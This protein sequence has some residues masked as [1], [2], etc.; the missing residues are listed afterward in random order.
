[1]A[2]IAENI[3]VVAEKL[4]DINVSLQTIANA[5]QGGKVTMDLS[6]VEQ[7][8]KDLQFNNITFTFGNT[9]ISFDGKIASLSII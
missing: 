1:M 5:I 8:L 3:Q 9:K 6:G 7:A 2:T 4:T